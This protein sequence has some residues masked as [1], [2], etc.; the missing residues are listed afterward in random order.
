MDAKAERDV[1]AKFKQLAEGRI[2]IIISHRLSA[3][4]MAD[5]IYFLKNG[6]VAESGTHD[7]LI[8]LD[9]NYAELYRIQAGH[10]R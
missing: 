5:C 8:K 3:V 2:A 1:F 7:E 10:Y 4:R 9:G 6:E